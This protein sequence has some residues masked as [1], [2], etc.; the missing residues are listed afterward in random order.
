M[1]YASADSGIPLL[2]NEHVLD[3]ANIP[4]FRFAHL[5]ALPGLAHGIF[6]RLGGVSK[7]PCSS[8][9]ASFHTSDRPSCVH[10]NLERIR[11]VM[12]ADRLVSLEQ[13][14]GQNVLII[15]RNETF[16]L[17]EP[18]VA[19]GLITDVPGLGLLIKQADCQAVI[20]FDPVRRVVANIHCGW[21]GNVADIL[22]VAVER[23]HRVFGCSPADLAA[24]VGPSLGPCC[25]EFKGHET[26]FPRGFRSVMV[27]PDHFDLWALSR[28]QLEAAGV[29][30]SSMA[31]ARICT[32]CR[33]D[34]F[35]SYR[36]EGN[37][38]RFATVAMIRA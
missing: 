7:L 8:L 9:N 31:F 10:V 1:T 23:M 26:I 34:L 16:R 27:K 13:V 17:H 24:A 20:L 15:R 38:G 11:R 12:G 33:T 14:H 29:P 4:V 36:G 32:R 37:T 35:F 22:G 5:H 3:G 21:R 18:L 30:P 2:H 28:A 6:T 19:D 25:G